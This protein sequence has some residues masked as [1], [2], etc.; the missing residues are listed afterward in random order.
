MSST[1]GMP[2]PGGWEMSMA[3]MRMPEQ[4]WLE[5][6]AAFLGMWTVMMVA[7]MLPSFIPMLARFRT[8]AAEAGR[9]RLGRLTALVALGYFAVWTLWGAVAFPLGAALAD[10]EMST[11]LF[12]RMV[13]AA[14]AVVVIAAGALQLSAWKRR[15]LDCCRDEP[16]RGAASLSAG[17]AFQHG[18][19]LGLR[20]SACCAGLTAVLLVVGVMDLRAMALVAAATAL[21]RIAPAGERFA[22]AIGV[23]AVAAGLVLLARAAGVA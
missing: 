10:V 2:M 11:P 20:C 1:G 4:S 5:A 7:M 6:A 19:R 16:A 12:A 15:Q 21:E 14:I 18:V 17:A 3:W 9:A 23:V 8:A 13:P 22:R